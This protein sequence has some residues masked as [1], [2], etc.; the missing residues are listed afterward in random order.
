[1]DFDELVTEKLHEILLKI[2]HNHDIDAVIA[3]KDILSNSE[4]IFFAQYDE[5]IAIG[6]L[7]SIHYVI[8]GKDY[9]YV[10]RYLNFVI[11]KFNEII[12]RRYGMH[13]F[14][15]LPESLNRLIYI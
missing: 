15:Y 13:I 4:F 5:G 7:G 12:C 3:P 11:N 1:M 10:Y 9:F 8:S 6:I 2:K 14:Q